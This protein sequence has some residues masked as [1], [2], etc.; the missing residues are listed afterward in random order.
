MYVVMM[1]YFITGSEAFMTG[2]VIFMFILMMASP[3]IAFYSISSLKPMELSSIEIFPQ[4]VL[5]QF[6]LFKRSFPFESIKSVIFVDE[7]RRR[8]IIIITDELDFILSI[9]RSKDDTGIFNQLENEFGL[10]A[11]QRFKKRR[12]IINNVIT[13]KRYKKLNSKKPF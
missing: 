6:P 5:I 8:E 11:G 4:E 12:S 1:I 3:I 2:F 9:S 7:F 13:Y 10:M